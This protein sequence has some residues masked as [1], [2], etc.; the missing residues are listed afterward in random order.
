MIPTN[1]PAQTQSKVSMNDSRFALFLFS[2]LMANSPILFGQTTGGKHV[3][4]F[5]NL[6][7]SAR[8]TGLGGYLITVQDDD[9]N[10]AA[11][12]PAALNP[13]MDGQL[14]FSHNF[15]PAGISGGYAGFGYCAA[16]WETS[17]HGGIQYLSYGKFDATN[18][19][20]QIEGE[21]KA[22]DYAITLGAA[23][24]LYERVTVGANLKFITSQLESYNSTGIAGDL[25][26]M[27]RDTASQINVSLVLRNIGA[28]LS[29]YASGNRESLPF[30]MQL[31]LSKRLRHL[32][33]RFSVVYR[34]LDR[35]NVL[36]DDPASAE[37][38]LFGEE[39]SKNDFV[40]NLAR[41][42]IFSGEFLLGN[43]DNFRIQLAYNHLQHQELSVR[44]LRSLTGFS[45]GF[46]MK[47]K[48]F[49]IEYGRSFLHLGAGLNHVGTSVEIR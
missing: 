28:Q 47:I 6:S 31:G 14:S 26:A 45:M 24:Q 20:G 19:A 49:R 38:T 36:Y 15:M 46:G 8:I 10:L 1:D 3:F 44:E 4:E 11:V 25:A 27:F 16:P 33:F 32:P 18:E 43:K 17:F 12:N 22:A 7:P 2:L 13:E 40:D 34:Y 48:R 21:F 35:W 29:T 41:H 5:L 30:E 9:V 37:T 42:F 39:I 23:R